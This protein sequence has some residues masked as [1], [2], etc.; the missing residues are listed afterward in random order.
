MAIPDYYMVMPY[1]GVC[2]NYFCKKQYQVQE[3][4]IP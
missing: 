3:M 4:L 2:F 1:C